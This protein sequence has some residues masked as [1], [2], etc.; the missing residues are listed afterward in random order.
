MAVL[1]IKPVTEPLSP[2]RVRRRPRAV[3]WSLPP[4]RSNRKNPSGVMYLIMKPISSAWASSMTTGAF[5][6][7]PLSVAQVLP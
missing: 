7:V 5:F 1:P 3:A 4:M 2:K 6:D